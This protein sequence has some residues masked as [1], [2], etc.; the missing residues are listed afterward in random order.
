MSVLHGILEEFELRPDSTTDYGVSCLERSQ[1]WI[2]GKN[3]VHTSTRATTFS[4]VKE[5]VKFAL[6][7]S[8]RNGFALIKYQYHIK[9]NWTSTTFCTSMTVSNSLILET[10][11]VNMFFCFSS[12]PYTR[13]F[14]INSVECKDNIS[15]GQELIKSEPSN[16]T[17]STYGKPNEQLFPMR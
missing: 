2:N 8:G 1:G 16:Y 15:K 5:I 10:L 17:M 3:A 9:F 7:S 11:S 14:R 12:G 13:F 4:I 6:H